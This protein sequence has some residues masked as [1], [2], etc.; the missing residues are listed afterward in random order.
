MAGGSSVLASGLGAGLGDSQG[1]DSEAMRTD[2]D[3]ALSSPVPHAGAR[4]AGADD[5]RQD[6]D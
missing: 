1:G 2:A 5:G 3:G 4:D 6:Q